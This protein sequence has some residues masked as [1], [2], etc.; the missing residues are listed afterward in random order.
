VR[1]TEPKFLIDDKTLL[2]SN[3]ISPMPEDQKDWDEYLTQIYNTRLMDFLEFDKLQYDLEQSAH[4]LT[5]P[6]T[7]EVTK[8]YFKKLKKLNSECMTDEEI[9]KDFVPCTSPVITTLRGAM[10]RDF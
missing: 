10:K 4:S 9:S 1:S 8:Y 2:P 7:D 6:F 5:K 3:E